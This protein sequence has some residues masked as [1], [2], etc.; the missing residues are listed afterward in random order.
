MFVMWPTK[1]T[2]ARNRSFCPHLRAKSTAVQ[3]DHEV[4]EVG[5]EPKF[6]GPRAPSSY[7]T[8]SEYLKDYVFIS[9][10]N[11]SALYLT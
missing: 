9:F 7:P 8:K 2:W 4:I 5:L 10:L 6:K 3:T 1:S 11:T